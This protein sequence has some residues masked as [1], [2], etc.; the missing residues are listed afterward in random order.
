MID[1]KQYEKK[2]KAHD[3][4]YQYSDDHGVWRAGKAAHDALWAEAKQSPEHLKLYQAMRK[5]HS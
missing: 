2:L 4:Y 5:L 1:L 3:W